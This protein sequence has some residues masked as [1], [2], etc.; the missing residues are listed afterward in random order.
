VAEAPA[1]RLYLLESLEADSVS[2][3][4]AACATTLPMRNGEITSSSRTRGS[5]ERPGGSS[6]RRRLPQD[7]VELVISPFRIG[8]NGRAPRSA[9]PNSSRMRGEWSCLLY[10]LESLE[11]DSR[12]R[13]PA[14]P[15]RARALPTCP[16][17]LHTWFAVRPSA[18]PTSPV[19]PAWAEATTQARLRTAEAK[20]A[21]LERRLVATQ[22]LGSSI[23]GSLFGQ[24]RL[25]FA[26]LFLRR[27][28]APFER[29]DFASLQSQLASLRRSPNPNASPDPN[30]TSPV[31]PAWAD[32]QLCQ[33][34]III[35]F[36]RPP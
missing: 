27:N 30:A 22:A 28:E 35:V 11:A 18:S 2:A 31:R 10:L 29:G 32:C 26:E 9:S 16:R 14:A 15:T 8:G 1:A 33:P 7:L 25:R 19:R 4:L 12:P 21:T 13:A 24:A 17:Q 20:V 5:G 23:L 36:A 6:W 3:P 34:T